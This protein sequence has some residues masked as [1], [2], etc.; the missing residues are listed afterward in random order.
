MTAETSE[1]AEGQDEQDRSGKEGV[2]WSRRRRGKIS[3]AVVL[4]LACAAVPSEVIAAQKPKKD[5]AAA[6]KKASAVAPAEPAGPPAEISP[7]PSEAPAAEPAASPPLAMP[8]SAPHDLHAS[9]DDRLVIEARNKQFFLQPIVILQ[10]L[11]TLPVNRAADVYFEGTGF[12]FRRGALGFDARLLGFARVFFLSNIASGSLALWDFFADLDPFEGKLVLRAGRFRPW[13]ARQ[14]LLAGDRYQ[15]IQLPVAM[16]DLLEMGDGRDLGA[17]LFGLLMDKKVEYN[18]GIWNGEHGIWSTGDPPMYKVEPSTDMLPRSGLRARGNIDFVYGLRLVG[19]PFGYL[20]ALDESDLSYSE[21]LRLSLGTAVLYEKRHD[22]YIPEPG[23]YT[24]VDDRVLKV[25]LELH[26]RL[27]GFSLE[28]EVFMRQ[29]WLQDG[30]STLALDAFRNY[31]MGALAWSAYVQGGYFL[32]PRVVELTARFDY[33]DVE[34]KTPGYILR[35][36][37]GLNWFLHGYNILLQIMYRANAGIGF[38]SDMGFYR[39]LRPLDRNDNSFGTRPIARLT[40]DL[41]LMLQLSL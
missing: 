30:A 37:L 17:G 14:R 23:G 12:T 36:A 29:A 5:S 21:T 27:R 1:T 32:L 22:Q 33:V 4:A 20:P 10:T 34:P 9:W 39:S 41:F 24:R 11:F 8:P 26:F 13:L 7:A 16:T 40:H 35:P 38:E 3:C 19:H 15:M 31:N 28:A 25:G 18:L 2:G 6:G